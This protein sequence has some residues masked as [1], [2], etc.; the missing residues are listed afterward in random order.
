MMGLLRV[1]PLLASAPYRVSCRIRRPLGFSGQDRCVFRRTIRWLLWPLSGTRPRCRVWLVISVEAEG[2]R[3]VARDTPRAFGQLVT[4]GLVKHALAVARRGRGG[5]GGRSRPRRRRSRWH[6]SDIGE[7]AELVAVDEPRGGLAV[8]RVSV[9]S[10][11]R[12]LSVA[13]RIPCTH[14][15]CHHGRGN[16][17]HPS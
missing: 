6:G 4:R 9:R 1:R 10:R 15:R 3:L 5:R 14:R 8:G 12:H 2:V 7:G 16:S 11:W 17:R 13:V